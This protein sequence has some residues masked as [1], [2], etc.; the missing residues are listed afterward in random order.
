MLS[1]AGLDQQEMLRKCCERAAESRYFAVIRLIRGQQKTAIVGPS[2]LTTL[3][4]SNDKALVIRDQKA[5]L[6]EA[7][8]LPW[9]RKADNY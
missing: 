8:S 1:G 9:R 3:R 5:E 7:P 4:I 2:A 6:R